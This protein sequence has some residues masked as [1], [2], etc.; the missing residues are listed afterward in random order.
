M[1]LAYLLLTEPKIETAGFEQFK[2]QTRQT[3]EEALGNPASLGSQA[4]EAA[5]YPDDEV[6]TKPLT[7]AQLDRLNQDAAQ[8]WLEKLIATSPIEVT[9]VGDLPK[10][11][12]VELVTRYV[13]SLP[14]RDRVSPSLYLDKRRLTAP[15]GPRV[16]EKTLQTITPQAFV[17]SGFYG[18]DETNIADARALSVASRVISTRMIKQLREDAQLV[19][20]IGAG[21]R[22]ASTYPGFGVFSS[23]ATT[24]P[25]KVPALVQQVAQ[26]YAAFAKD[27]PTADELA[28][29]KKQIAN[30]FASEVDT[31]AYWLA[32]LNLLTFRGNSLDDIVGAPAAFQ[33]ISASEVQGTFAKYY[34][35]DHSIIVTVIPTAP[36]EGAK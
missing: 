25:A 13:A 35:K 10:E 12:A 21:S 29:A 30:T 24:D 11:K 7:V 1:Q 26:M 33:A 14:S 6:R 5:P 9:I 36:T 8:A 18:A 28:L 32:R 17:S 27:G 34:S 15:K 20:S 2:T 3:L 16:I 31:P 19:Y 23:S 4:A 22:P